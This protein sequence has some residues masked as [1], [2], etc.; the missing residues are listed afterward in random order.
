[1]LLASMGLLGRWQLPSVAAQSGFGAAA[2]SSSQ[3]TMARHG[4]DD[5][6]S[7]LT[8]RTRARSCTTVR[9]WA[10]NRFWER[11]ASQWSASNLRPRGGEV[12]SK[13]SDPRRYPTQIYGFPAPT[14]TAVPAFSVWER[15]VVCRSVLLSPHRAM[16]LRL[17]RDAY[18][19]RRHLLGR[20]L[21]SQGRSS[22]GQS[23]PP[24][25]RW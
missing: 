2:E 21:L 25:T 16:A 20:G 18:G 1:V 7:G 23:Q 13:S 15:G 10:S 9:E 8:L 24:A 22:R 19:G 3:G 14:K 17:C 5:G 4:N 12:T 6:C 11:S